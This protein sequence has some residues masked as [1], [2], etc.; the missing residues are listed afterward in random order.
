VAGRFG[1]SGQTDYSAANA[2]LCSLS[3]SLRRARPATRAIAIDWTAWGGIGMATRGSIPKVMEMAGIEMLAPEVGIPTVRREL[4]A[5]QT[6]DEIVVGGRLGILVDEW[7]DTG[8]LDTVKVGQ[9]LASRVPPLG[10]VGKVDAAHLYGGLSVSTP[11]DPSGQPF[12]HDHQLE[13]TPLLPGVM[14]TEAFA[15]VASVLCPAHVVAGVE[16]VEFLLPFKFFRM[17]PATLHLSASG[18]AAGGGDVLVDVAL[19]SSVQP[20]PD[21]PPQVRLHFRGQVR[22]SRTALPRPATAFTPPE[23]AERT[24]DRDTIYRVYFHGPAYKVLDE[25]R[26]TGDTAVGVMVHGLPPNARPEGAASIMAPRLIELCFQ[27]AGIEQV[28]RDGTLGLPTAFAAARAYRQPEEADGERLY[29][30][31]ARRPGEALVYDARVVDGR[32]RVYVELDGYRTITLPGPASLDLPDSGGS[33][34]TR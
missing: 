22:M 12:L 8:G 28:A 11:L 23:G 16:Q 18:R 27:A 34:G 20:R 26:L 30:V 32:G 33:Q 13:G 3:R 9:W 21:H 29:A 5:G 10:M 25:V 15:Q 2:L 19:R 6:A 1:N 24:V 7:D 4:T 31:A 17:Q 14:G